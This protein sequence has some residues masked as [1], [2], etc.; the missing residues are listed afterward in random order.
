MSS[1]LNSHLPSPQNSTIVREFR[2]A[3]MAFQRAVHRTITRPLLAHVGMPLLVNVAP[4]WTVQTLTR[5]FI[6]PPRI[7]HTAPELRALER[8]AYVPIPSPHGDLAAWRFAPPADAAAERA[9]VI[10]VSHGW[11]GRGAQFRA[12]VPE[13]LRAGYEVWLF[14]HIAHGRSAGREAPITAFAHG[15]SIVVDRALDEHRTIAGFIG[16]SLG[17]AAI[18]LALSHHPRLRSLDAAERLRVVMIAPPSSLIRY[19]RFFARAIGLPERL[20]AA[21]Q[22]RL[23]RKTGLNWDEL[24]MPQAVASLRSAA[25]VIHDQHDNDVRI[26][27]GLALARAWSGASF[28]RT[29]GLGHTRVLR[30]THVVGCAVGFLA[31]QVTFSPAPTQDEWSAFSESLF[32]VSPIY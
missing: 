19:S 21:M 31:E 29:T 11:G 8:A 24:E 2:Q 32:S 17:C 28:M 16:H 12:F 18:G 6:T 9:P 13:L 3:T 22:W 23:E 27:S 15:L 20:R 1:S 7:A 26:D 30:N 25:L 14:D 4:R 10:I 5:R